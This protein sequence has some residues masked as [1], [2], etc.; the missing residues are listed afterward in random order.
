MGAE[1][2]VHF[3]GKQSVLGACMYW[4]EELQEGTS[5]RENRR[6]WIIEE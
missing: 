6:E 4:L 5:V 1:A 3:G 2:E